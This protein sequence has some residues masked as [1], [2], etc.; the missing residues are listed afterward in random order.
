VARKPSEIS[1]VK[2]PFT[3]LLRKIRNLSVVHKICAL[4][5]LFVV[6]IALLVG[7]SIYSIRLQTALRI[8]LSDELNS[9]ANTHAGN[10]AEIGARSLLASWSL[11]FLG[12]GTLML[13]VLAALVIWNSVL[14]PLSEITYTTGR[15]AA[16]KLRLEI[17]HIKRSDEI[18]HLAYAVQS[19]QDAMIRN[20]ELQELG[21]V[22]ARERDAVT[23]ER[24][25]L[26]DRYHA[27]KW[28]LNAAVSNMAQGLLMIDSKADVLVIN[29]QYKKIYNLPP[30]TIRS[31]CSLQDL[32]RHRAE[33]GLFSGNA[34][35][36]LAEILTRM[37]ERKPSVNEIKLADGRTIRISGR[38]M[39]GGGWITT[40]EDVTEQR[41]VQKNLERTERFL[42]AVIE[43]MSEAILAKDTRSLRYVFANR[44]AEI[45]F[46]IS[47]SE[48]VG[49]TARE[50]F[51]EESAELIEHDDQKLLAGSR[52]VEVAT[53]TVQI[54]GNGRRTL[55]VRRLLIA[56][57]DSEPQFLLSMVEDRT[58]QARIA[59]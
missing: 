58:D 4:V 43:N 18:G 55:A 51:P 41:R 37:A 9:F 12:I 42:L 2:K 15:I 17:P 36:Y 28:Q 29:A 52:E 33:T 35:V 7:T 38:S 46:G 27:Q 22:T 30:E 40:H 39:A 53:H 21:D 3:Y 6:L 26:D 32:V 45:L 16:G 48:I 44:A 13:A 34:D 5:M 57:Q 25:S 20:L 8:A 11:I 47:R 54:P 14:R 19:F 49:R 24:N 50:L 59:A 1:I 31:G 23:E 10:V 56:D